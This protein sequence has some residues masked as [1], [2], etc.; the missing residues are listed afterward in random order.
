M[1]TLGSLH[2]LPLF[3]LLLSDFHHQ[4]R[5]LRA[6]E[7]E[8][9]LRKQAG[10]QGGSRASKAGREQTFCSLQNLCLCFLLSWGSVQLGEGGYVSR[11]SVLGSLWV[12]CHSRGRLECGWNTLETPGKA[13]DRAQEVRW[14]HFCGP[15][16]PTPLAT[17]TLWV[18]VIL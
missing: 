5:D 14:A 18:G 10:L 8:A 4:W 11:T 6:R 15:L 13:R 16:T 3:W 2:C 1:V 12:L 17:T 7:Q 9:G